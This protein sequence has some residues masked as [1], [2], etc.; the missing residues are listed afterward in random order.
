MASNGERGD[1]GLRPNPDRSPWRVPLTRRRLIAGAALLGAGTELDRFV[2]PASGE[3]AR[4]TSSEVVP[5]HGRH[6]AGIATP[7]QR[8]LVFA[9]FDVQTSS[10]HALRRLL[11]RWSD[12]AAA[13]TAGREPSLQD[14]GEAAGLPPSRLTLTFGLGPTLFE[15]D[16]HDRFGL[17]L[18]R[19]RALAPLPA[20]PG[21]ALEASRSGGDLCVQACADD[22]Q[23]AFHAVHLLSH[24]AGADAS[25][26]WTQRGFWHSTADGART[27]RNLLGFK[28]GTANLRGDNATAMNRLV[29]VQPSDQPPWLRD[30]TYLIIRRIE[31]SLESWDSLPIHQQERVVGREKTSGA[32]LGRHHEHDPLDLRA[33]NAHGSPVIPIDAHVRVAADQGDPAQRILRRGYSYSDASHPDGSLDAGLFFVAFARDPARQFIPL[34]HR[35]A[36]GDALSM[37]TVHTASAI[38]ACPPGAPR[39]GFVGQG[40]FS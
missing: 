19:P 23:V 9:A 36:T 21:D 10:A 33:L 8:E 14:T 17:A 29:W 26:R 28:D 2:A 35:L 39:G 32:P 13:V 6:Q 1:H 37:F 30:G 11:E 3:I 12:A 25:L 34:Q 5:F 22:T 38:F 7:Q 27:P 31:I 16:G 18:R 20:F 40:L 15:R 4:S 24:L